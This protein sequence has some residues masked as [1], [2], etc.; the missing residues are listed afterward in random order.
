MRD[1]RK[2]GNTLAIGNVNDGTYGKYLE[3][4]TMMEF[5]EYSK[6]EQSAYGGKNWRVYG[7]CALFVTWE[8][9]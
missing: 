7:I 4:N 3:M 2:T 6:I 9:E 5:W 8:I 1:K